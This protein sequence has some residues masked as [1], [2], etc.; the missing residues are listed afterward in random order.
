MTTAAVTVS[1]VLREL[2]RY[3]L[4][5]ESAVAFPSVA[6]LV[7]GEPVRGSWWAHPRSHEIYDLTQRLDEH[8]DVIL[9]KLVSGKNTFVYRRLWP[10]LLAASTGRERWQTVG[11]SDAARR[12]LRAV[13]H[14]G[15]LCTD[16]IPW[17]GGRKKDSP[18][19]AARELERRLLVYSEEVHTESGR[20]AKQLET[21]EHWAAGAGISLGAMTAEE[22]RRMLED[23]VAK[24]NQRFRANGR[25]PWQTKV[26]AS[27]R[28]TSARASR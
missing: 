15:E 4:L 18:G 25:L 22:G 28:R 20:H 9:C 8:R 3:G 6:A 24:M 1:Q 26:P 17:P 21:W 27:S 10:A 2:R 12:L 23:A 5:L 19:A 7:A 14:S 13:R 11:L 16:A